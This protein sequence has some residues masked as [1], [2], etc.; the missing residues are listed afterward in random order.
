MRVV[1]YIHTSVASCTSEHFLTRQELPLAWSG[2]GSTWHVLV[3]VSVAFVVV[4]VVVVVAHATISALYCSE[5]LRCTSIATHI[6]FNGKSFCFGISSSMKRSRSYTTNR[7]NAR[8][9]PHTPLLTRRIYDWN[10][11][12]VC[13]GEVLDVTKCDIHMI[14][15][16][17]WFI[18]RRSNRVMLMYK[19]SKIIQQVW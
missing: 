18:L 12:E 17:K 13:D 7:T 10:L 4:V 6:A 2:P 19:S 14:D 9:H 16:Y 5:S 15:R 8:H 11:N 3:V 1:I